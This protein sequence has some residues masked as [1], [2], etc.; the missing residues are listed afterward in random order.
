MLADVVHQQ[1][2]DRSSII[3]RRDGAIPFLAGRIPDLCL[4]GLGVDLDRA[5]RKLDPDRRLGIQVELIPRESTQ[6]VGFTYARIPD[7][8]H[9]DRW[10]V[11]FTRMRISAVSIPLKRNYRDR[12]QSGS[13]HDHRVESGLTSYSSL[14]I[15]IELSCAVRVDVV[16]V[17]MVEIG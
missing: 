6:Q 14:A 2:P 8:H 1:R 3:C 11:F 16:I 12:S 9:L 10:S 4:D 15:L 5:S 17:G 7:E 13:P